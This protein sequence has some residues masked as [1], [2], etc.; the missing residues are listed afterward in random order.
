MTKCCL[1]MVGMYGAKAEVLGDPLVLRMEIGDAERIYVHSISGIDLLVDWGDGV[2]SA[3]TSHTY[4]ENGEYIVKVY[5]GAGNTVSCGHRGLVEVIQWGSYEIIGFALSDK[6]VSGRK[7][8][9]LTKVPPLL[10]EYVTTCKGMF[11]SATSFNFDISSW[12]VSRVTNM[13]SMFNG[14]AEFNQDISSWNVSKVTT[15]SNTFDTARKFNQDLSSWDIGNVTTLRETFNSAVTFNQNLNDW[16]TS[17]VTTLYG[18]FKGAIIFDQPLDQWDVSSVT[19]LSWTFRSASAFNQPIGNWKVGRVSLMSGTFE[20][21]TSFD[22]PLGEWDVSNVSSFESMFKGAVVFDQDIGDWELVG[23][24]VVASMFQ[25]AT[26]FN[27]DISRWDVSKILIFDDMFNG[28]TSFNQDIGSWRFRS[29]FG[30]CARM[31]KGA[32]SFNADL[33]QWNLYL[34]DGRYDGMAEMFC[35]AVSFNSPIFSIGI[36]SVTAGEIASF[37]GMFKGAILFNQDMSDWFRQSS[38]GGNMEEMFSGA[39][40]FNQDLSSWCVD[41]TPSMPGDFRKDTPAWTLPKPNWG[42][43]C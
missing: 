17:N 13:E 32:S 25:N 35:D 31:F 33:S 43:P 12:D 28:A 4:P 9:K 16:D 7:S 38:L 19:S 22:Q 11:A 20:G 42:A 29:D 23:D 2:I 1:P 3:D 18:T 39:K 10:P 8:T 15:L 14:A 6:Y 27:Q 24:T 26:A 36:G 41:Q 21:A 34:L 30:S 40:A 37:K 5:G